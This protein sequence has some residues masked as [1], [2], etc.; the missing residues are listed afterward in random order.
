MLR[1]LTT[2][3]LLFSIVILQSCSKGRV[4]SPASTSGPGPAQPT[5][6]PVPG[7][8]APTGKTYLA[9]GDS[10]TIGSNVRPQ[11]RFPALTKDW[12]QANSVNMVDPQF[13]AGSGWTTYVLQNQIGYQTVSHSFDA[14]SLL[15]GVNDQ[16]LGRD[17]AEYRL[18]FSQLLQQA[19][20]FANERPTHVFVLSIPDYS[21][22]PFAI[23]SDTAKIR[24]EIDIYNAINR[25][26]ALARNARYLDITPSTRLAK[27]DPTLLASD[28]LH[29][30]GLE[31][32]KW[33]ALLGPMMKAVIQ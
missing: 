24:R 21:V 1:I 23:Y 17:T 19:I 25:Q 33:A 16:Y 29:P 13:I 26:E 4:V 2:I 10:Y 15:I 6:G 32:K 30:S 22:T 5:P 8:P 18:S 7:A 9:L 11:E 3:L 28:G 27:N 20:S 31:Y 12:L 14:V